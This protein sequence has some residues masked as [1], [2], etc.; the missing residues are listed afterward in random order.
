MRIKI[1]EFRARNKH[2]NPMT[3]IEVEKEFPYM[4]YINSKG[5]RSYRYNTLNEAKEDIKSMYGDWI[6]FKML[7]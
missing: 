3:Y 6:D 2:D 5:D 7:I 1:C 4:Y